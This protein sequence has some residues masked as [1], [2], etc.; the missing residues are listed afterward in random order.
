MKITIIVL[1]ALLL[2][3]CFCKKETIRPP[4]PEVEI[5]RVEVPVFKC[6]IN[7]NDINVPDRPVMITQSLSIDEKHDIG[8]VA[9]AYKVDIVQLM[10]YAQEL[11]IGFNA[12]R[13]ICALPIKENNN[14]IK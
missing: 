5:Q 9:Q 14:E 12:Y 11:E 4:L 10:K 13:G 6:P 8:L 1:I 3:G 7:H 2:S